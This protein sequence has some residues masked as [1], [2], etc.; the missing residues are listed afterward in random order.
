MKSVLKY[1]LFSLLLIIIDQCIK[2]WVHNN[3]LPGYSGQ[4]NV[5]GDFVKLHYV[6]NRGMAFGLEI[7]IA[8]GKVILTVFR[9]VAMVL[10]GI[11]LNYLYQKKFHQG[12][13][14]CVAAILGGAIGNLIDS[15]FYGVAL[16]NAPFD[17]P[18]PWFHGQVIDMFFFDIYEG[19]LPNW[20]P[21]FGG[22]W[23]STPIFNFADACIFC[24]VVTILI[25]QYRFFKEP[26]IEGQTVGNEVEIIEDEV[27]EI[28][29]NIEID[30]LENTDN[31]LNIKED[32]KED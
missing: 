4:I 19:V 8:N 32:D 9:L 26:E 23:Y 15:I 21:Y 31:Q 12:L 2:L 13:L 10:I 22:T 18:S 5:I 3:M 16:G 30:S 27:K 24:G 14:W 25:F 6:L 17:A 11:Y 28:D 1:F 29:E 20:I 7:P